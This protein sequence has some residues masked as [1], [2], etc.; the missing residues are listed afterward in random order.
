M[1]K[2]TE[3]V[4]GAALIGAA[5]G[6]GT[7]FYKTSSYKCKRCT[8]TYKPSFGKWIS[9]MNLGMRKYMKCPE[10]G[11]WNLHERVRDIDCENFLD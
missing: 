3:V 11:N 5:V 9:G 4:I 7:Y 1:N 10:C 6:V 8:A 2:A